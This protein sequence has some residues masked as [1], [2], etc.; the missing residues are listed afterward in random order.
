MRRKRKNHKRQHKAKKDEDA[1]TEV[2]S[3]EEIDQLLTAINAGDT[4]PE[5]FRP[6]RDGRRI[7]IY[8]FMRPDKFSKEQ[9]RTMSILHETFARQATFTLTSRFKVPCHIHVASVDQLT[10][11]EFI[12]SIPTPT[13]MAVLNTGDPL[14]NKIVIEIDPA[15]S[16]SFI[17][18]AFGGKDFDVKCQH[19]LTRIE[20]IVMKAVIKELMG[21]LSE[22]WKFIVPELD[23]SIDHVDTSPQFINLSPPT[24]M[25][26]LITAEAKIGELEGMINIC[27][28]QDCLNGIIEKLTAA[29]WYGT[30]INLQKKYKLANRWD[31]PVEMV[32][33]IF[34]RDYPIQKILAWKDEELLLPLVI[35]TPNTCYLRFDNSRIFQCE[36]LED[37]KWFPK[38]IKIIGIAGQPRGTEGKMELNAINPSVAEALAE[39]GV[40]ISV[41]LGRTAKTINEILKM[42]EGTIVE[43]DKLAGEPVDIK[44]NGVLIAKGEVVVIVEN[45][46][47]R[48]TE[49]VKVTSSLNPSTESEEE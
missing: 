16:F 22:G 20:W 39:A 37:D 43:L 5:A 11:E 48:V 24:D 7:K 32:A 26:V 4:E 35:R 44:A 18:R 49:I 3:Q 25:T 14:A 10:Y 21:C 46:G 41:E 17:N 36:I 40:T 28:P 42:G 27:Y 9:I 45:F 8:D 6:A 15:V 34:R 13:T 1:P 31:V 33:E 19:E 47:V 23:I 30:K 2:L 12:R 29:Y 38:K